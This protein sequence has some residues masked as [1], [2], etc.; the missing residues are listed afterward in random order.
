[1]SMVLGFLMKGAHPGIK[2][3]SSKLIIEI[4]VQNKW[5]PVILDIIP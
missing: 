4:Y 2:M 3:R 1:M 5:P